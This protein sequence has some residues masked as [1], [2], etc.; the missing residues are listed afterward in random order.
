MRAILTCLLATWLSCMNAQHADLIWCFGDSAG[1]DFSTINNPVAISSSGRSRGSSTS[2]SDS[3]GN[4]LFY[5]QANSEN[6]W[7][8]PNLGEVFT[9]N[10]QLMG[11]GDSVFCSG[12][13]NE[14]T[15]IPNPAN[16][17][18]FYLF[19]IGITGVYGIRYAKI[20]MRLNGGIGKVV[21]KN[22]ILSTDSVTDG[23]VAV[24]HA[25]GRDWWLLAHDANNLM[26]PQYRFF[27]YL[28]S[29]DSIH[30]KVAQVIG[31]AGRTAAS[32]MKFSP[33]GNKLL[34]VSY[35][36]LIEL[37][38]FDR[39]SGTLSNARTISNEVF[40]NFTKYY[41]GCSFSPNENYIYVS[42]TDNAYPPT[43]PWRLEQYDITQPTAA[44]IAAT[45][46]YIFNGYLPA[47]GGQHKL[48]P[49]G[50]I[51]ITYWY[52]N[53]YPYADTMYNQY[54]MNLSVIEQPDSPGVACNYNPFSFYLG[55]QRTYLSLPNNPNYELGALVGS[56]CDTLTSSPPTPQRGELPT[57]Q[58]TF[59]A[60]EQLVYVNAAGIKGG[61]YCLQIIDVMGKTVYSHKEKTQASYFS[62]EI[63]C[64]VWRSGVY[65][66]N[67]QTEKEKLT[68]K[69]VKQ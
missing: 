69:V 28:I 46:T 38:D 10:N 25:N 34:M 54:N 57:L 30:S 42:N 59:A 58:A 7:Y 9:V 22:I 2:I 5:S 48:G 19:S 62:K 55:G 4:L 3:N 64:A 16:D 32:R 63:S 27:I 13:Y 52:A 1:I 15:I 12:W 14:L 39:C 40:P 67:L 24:K 23:P 53:W 43:S 29:P 36:D 60:N 66:V 33:S 61:S 26:N 50:K 6:T 49:D 31:T 18:T 51:Y 8:Y 35:G 11:N 44:A 47:S 37:Y 20:D 68:A 41:F 65:L 45:K 17:S 21:S 56:A